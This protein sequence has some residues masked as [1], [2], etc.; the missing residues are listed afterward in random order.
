MMLDIFGLCSVN[1]LYVLIG[2]VAVTI[3]SI[4]LAIVAIA[5][6]SSM[7]KKYESMM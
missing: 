3:I 5:K 4:I 6:S 7:K 1:I 2:M